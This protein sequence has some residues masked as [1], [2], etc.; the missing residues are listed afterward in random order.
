MVLKTITGVVY[1]DGV[2]VGSVSGS[3]EDEYLNQSSEQV[4]T[5]S[6]TVTV[7][8]DGVQVGTGTGSYEDKVTYGSGGVESKTITGV[9]Y[10]DGVQVGSVSGSYEDQYGAVAAKI[11]TKLTLIVR[12][13]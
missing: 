7:Y 6:I 2:Q 10:V 4:V 5:R 13:L 1:V 12:R 11:P 9:V 8:V 3:Y